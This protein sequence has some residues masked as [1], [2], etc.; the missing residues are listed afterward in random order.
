MV[1]ADSAPPSNMPL[2]E[3]FEI[4]FSAKSLKNEHSAEERKGRILEGKPDIFDEFSHM[5]NRHPRG[6]RLSGHFYSPDYNIFSSVIAILLLQKCQNSPF[7][8]VE[9]NEKLFNADTRGLSRPTNLLMAG[10]RQ[11]R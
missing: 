10:S 5:T 9:S 1:K 11:R 2:K 3:S 8:Q 4:Q 7:F 6:A